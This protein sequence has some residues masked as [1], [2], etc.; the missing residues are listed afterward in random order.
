M[1][2]EKAIGKYF[3]VPKIA[4]PESRTNLEKRNAM[5]NMLVYRNRLA[6][7]L[8]TFTVENA[9]GKYFSVPKI[10]S[11]EARTHLL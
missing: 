8:N 2:V 4:S 6:G 9:I 10:A 5:Q 3:S 1:T 7:G 11:P